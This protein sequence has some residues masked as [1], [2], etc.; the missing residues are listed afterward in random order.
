MSIAFAGTHCFDPVCRDAASFDCGNDG[1]N[2]WRAR[3]A[4]QR[5]RRDATRTFVATDE[6]ELVL[7]YYTRVAG[8]LEHSA[9]TTAVRS[10]KSPHFPIPVALLARL[11]VDQ[12]TQRQ[13]L[14]ALLLRDALVRVRA[15]SEQVAVHAVVVHAID[16]P[17]AAFYE[18]FGFQALTTMP[19]TLMVT[20]AE[21]RAAGF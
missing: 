2:R 1:L 12:S 5:E 6:H 14:G 21:L 7:G 10:G 11:A 19:C 20:L 16:D 17:A 18:Q 8:Q 4:G 3:S 9:A 15:A 13:G